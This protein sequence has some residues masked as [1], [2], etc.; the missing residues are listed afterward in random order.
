MIQALVFDL[1]DTL[2]PEVDFVTGGYRAVARYVC[3]KYGGS[4]NEIFCAMMTRFTNEGRRSVF[5]MVV[6]RFLDPGVPVAELVEVYRRHI[7]EIHMFPGY[8]CLL[9]ELSRN[10]RLGILTDGLPEV[11]KRKVRAL[12]LEHLVDK[13]IYTWDYGSEMEKPHPMTFSLML[14]YLRAEPI[15]ALY[16]GDNPAKDCK[17]AHQAGM[18]FAQLRAPS[19]C[20][21]AAGSVEKPEFVIDSLYQLPRILLMESNE[22]S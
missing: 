3:E 22:T 16:V 11:Q 14:D 21:T 20:D 8:S 7:P 5:P 10:Y 12:G 13:I 4:Y 17:G 19:C 15:N 1:D 6:E 9:Q 2:Y 18:K